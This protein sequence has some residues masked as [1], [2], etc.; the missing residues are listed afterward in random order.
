MN[1]RL[2]TTKKWKFVELV[3]KAYKNPWAFINV[4]TDFLCISY[5]C[6]FRKSISTIFVC[7]YKLFSCS[8]KISNTDITPFTIY[9]VT[10]N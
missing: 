10:V 7:L 4:P 3:W 8:Y 6:L 9:F 2:S 1:G 5:I